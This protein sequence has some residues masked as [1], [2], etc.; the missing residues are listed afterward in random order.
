MKKIMNGNHAA[1][2]ISYAFTDVAALFPITPSSPMAEQ[3]EKWSAERKNNIF[4]YP[5]HTI[6]MQSEIGV[7]GAMHGMLKSGALATAYTCSQGL[8]LMLPTLYKLVGEL[9]PAVI[10][11]SSRSIAT[12]A[13]SIYGDHSDVMAARQTGVVM[14]ASGNVQEVALFSTAA[15]LAAIKGRLPIL[16]FFDGF[17]TSHEIRK[18]EVPSYDILY[19]YVDD[20]M[21]DAFRNNSLSNFAPKVYG[22]SETPDIF[23]QQREAS[24]IIHLNMES[25]IKQIIRKLNPLFGTQCSL[26]DYKGAENAEYV[27]IAMGSVQETIKQVVCEQNALG[28]KYGLLAVHLYRP[29]PTDTFLNLIPK[30]IRKIAVL[31]RTKEP[32]STGEPLLLDVQSACNSLDIPPKI[33]GGR[34]GIGSKEVTPDQIRSIFIELEK[35]HPK[36]RFTIGIDDNVTGLSLERYGEEDLTDWRTFQA[37]IWGFGSDGAVTGAGHFIEI[38]GEETEKDVQGQFYYSPSK[39]RNM[40]LSHL[41][42]A[43]D[44]IQSSYFVKRSNMV[45]CY[46]EQY[47]KQYDVLDGLQEEGTFLLNTSMGE[48]A[49]DKRLP[50]HVK[51]YLIEHKINFYIINANRLARKYE[52]GPILNTI[53]MTAMLGLTNFLEF[54]KAKETYQE[55]LDRGKLS[56]H[57]AYK[58]NM[59]AAM[60]ESIYWIKKV[61]LKEMGDEVLEEDSEPNHVKNLFTE[62]IIHPMK[63]LNGAS[64]T[65]ED[66]IDS[67]MIDGSLPLGTSWKQHH[68]YADKIPEWNSESC[69]QCN[70]CSVICPHATIRPFVLNEEENA[71]KPTTMST[72]IEK[73]NKNQHF[74][75]QVNPNFCTGCSLCESICPA[76]NK[77]IKMVEA[78]ENHV[79]REVQNWDFIMFRKNDR[80][81][82]ARHTVHESQFRQPLFEFVNACAGCGE[83]PYIKLLT[84]LFGERLSIAN[85]TGCSS[86]W[87]GSTPFVPYTLNQDKEGPTWANS[88]FENNAA[89]GMGMRIGNQVIKN[90]VKMLIKKETGNPLQMDHVKD[91]FNQWLVGTS[92]KQK[93]FELSKKLIS[94]IDKERANSE[95][96]ESIYQKRHYVIEKSQW[97]IGGDGWAYDIDFAGIDHVLS[98]GEDVNILILDNEGYA[99]TG[100]QASKASP[101]GANLKLAS[102]GKKE[103]KKDIGIFAMN[104]EHV[105]VAQVCLPANPQQTIRAL[106]EAEEFPGP[107]III[108]YSP[109]ILNG[110]KDNMLLEGKKATECGYWPLYR[111]NPSLI[112]QGENPMKFDS[113]QPNWGAFRGFLL[114]Q[115]R[116]ATSE[117]LNA[118]EADQL[119]QENEADARKRYNR[120]QMIQ[121]MY[122]CAKN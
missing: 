23:F 103:A 87:G 86:I 78:K 59:Y 49:I 3:I 11:V 57:P 111:F 88:L 62:K 68:G 93:Q 45:V 67:G 61:K 44:K 16:H 39:T 72:S 60:G 6:S 101:K 17:Q 22:A 106:T 38:I 36:R 63:N 118:Y 74:R 19:K 64:I 65:T 98:K 89:F 18:I 12:S 27:I 99:N 33:I 58:K 56:K 32:G 84:Q 122:K 82:N 79:Q 26:V 41:R 97:L 1:A 75:I 35:K 66:I 95:I 110:N 81:T 21:L 76:K 9:L 117:N 46:K 13:L 29:F 119:L 114:T 90:Q 55:I 92:D 121:E 100:G 104:Y 53:M 8:L 120:Y 30:S 37:K 40:T 71:N 54:Q 28:K 24:N 43:D 50:H 102:G 2:Y 47:L 42:I 108:A 5:V 70:L 105:Y 96:L 48:E 83:T 107:S 80:K 14:L 116:F 25:V 73:K 20:E 7:A 113:K 94:I 31:D 77:A 10:H 112:L 69:I 115:K 4:H 85:A 109:C 15:H 52:L 91:I 51:K 34:Y